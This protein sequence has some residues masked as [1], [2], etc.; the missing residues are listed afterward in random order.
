MACTLRH[1]LLALTLAMLPL[2]G[3]AQAPYP[4]KLVR[5]IIPYPAGSAV[6]GVGRTLFNRLSA[7]LGQQVIV[8]NRVGANGNVGMAQAAQSP[9]DGYTLL[10]TPTQLV[11]NPG[12]GKTGYDPLKDFAPVML[13]SRIP[14]VLVVPASSTARTVAELA[15]LAKA[16]PGSL[17]YASGGYGGIGH[18]SGEALKMGGG[19]DIAH[20]PYKSAAEQVNSVIAGDTQLAFPAMSL[21]LPHIVSG[22]LRALAVTGASRHPLLPEVPTMA[23]ALPPGFVLEAWYGLLAPTGV[24]PE[25]V[26][27]LNAEL[28][29][30]LKEPE[31]R[32][33]LEAGS[34]DI[35]GSSPTE[36]GQ[37][38]AK[39]LQVWGDLARKLN[40]KID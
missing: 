28:A 38:I 24:S 35:V 8:D 3:A 13:T 2:L 34:H 23:Q 12:L 5:V 15:A 32:K 7:N 19:L 6:D 33:V 9:K 21:A 37:V 25:V 26:A 14:A 10:F 36:F 11:S 16:K 22:R 31:V 39:D 1:T 29:K 4:D 20:I 17:S 30:V 27:R 40:V 18:F